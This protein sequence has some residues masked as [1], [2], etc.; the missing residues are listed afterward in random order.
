MIDQIPGLDVSNWQHDRAKFASMTPAEARRYAADRNA[1]AR[2]RGLRAQNGARPDRTPTI[3]E[4]W[5]RAMADAR[6]R[7]RVS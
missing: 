2:S 6:G 7:R 3:A 1:E 4:S 5:R